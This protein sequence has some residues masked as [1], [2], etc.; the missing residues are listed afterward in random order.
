[1]GHDSFAVGDLT[2]IIGDNAPDEKRGQRAGYNGLWSLRHRESDRSFFVPGIAGLNF[3]HIISGEGENE[4]D[5]FFE[6][7]RSPMSFRRLS[8]TAGELHQPPT[9]T[10]FLESWTT[11]SLRAPHYVDM[12]FRFRATQHVFDRGYIGLFWASYMN[13]PQDKSLYF[14]GG[15]EGDGGLD[16]WQQLCSPAHNR[17]CTVR[18]YGDEFE[19]TFEEGAPNALYKNFSPQRFS[20]PYYYGQFD[21]FTVIYLF[22]RSEG[23]RFTHSPSGGGGNAERETTNPAWDFQYL[24]PDY[25][26]AREYGFRMRAVFRPRCTRD[27][28]DRE[29]EEWKQ[30]GFGEG[31]A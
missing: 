12:D 27:E 20:R 19:M 31:R 2:A 30:A 1:M 16:R 22:D 28:V 4:R 8:G 17:D 7:R 11:F 24:V 18:G 6:P 23:I 26:V 3:E 25:E 14:R 13:A 15:L 21:D 9:E 10:F 29:Y 5:I